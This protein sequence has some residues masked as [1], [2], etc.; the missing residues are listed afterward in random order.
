M[1]TT[2]PDTVQYEEFINLM[3]IILGSMFFR[4]PKILQ[5]NLNEK[6]FRIA[7]C[8]LETPAS[9][10]ISTLTR[11]FLQFN[12]KEM[13]LNIEVAEYTIVVVNWLM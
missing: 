3:I 7:N 8:N 2:K 5:G 13:S 10:A 6:W 11:L 9:E 1:F 12:F 4:T